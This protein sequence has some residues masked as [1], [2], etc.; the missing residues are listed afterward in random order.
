MKRIFDMYQ[1]QG[2]PV[3]TRLLVPENQG[4]NLL[5]NL[6][7]E[8][9]IKI[10]G[11]LAEPMWRKLSLV[12]Q[13]INVIASSDPL[14]E[15]IV[16]PIL[17][18]QDLEARQNIPFKEYGKYILCPSKLV[19]ANESKVHSLAPRSQ[20]LADKIKQVNP[21]NFN[22]LNPKEAQT[23]LQEKDSSLF[24]KA[25]AKDLF[26]GELYGKSITPYYFDH[27]AQQKVNKIRF[28][29]FNCTNYLITFDADR[30][31]WI[32]NQPT[33]ITFTED[34]CQLL[35]YKSNF[36]LHIYNSDIG[37]NRIS[38][39]KIHVNDLKLENL[40]KISWFTTWNELFRQRAIFKDLGI[41]VKKIVQFIS[42]NPQK[43]QDKILQLNLPN[44]NLLSESEVNQLMENEHII[45]LMAILFRYVYL[46]QYRFVSQQKMGP[47]Q[48][49]T[50]NMTPYVINVN[51]EGELF[52]NNHR[53]LNSKSKPRAFAKEG[54]YH[55]FIF[56]LTSMYY[57]RVDDPQLKQMSIK[58]QKGKDLQDLDKENQKLKGTV[59][60]VGNP[61]ISSIPRNTIE[62]AER[63]S[64][65]LL[66]S[67]EMD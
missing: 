54:H 63:Y 67:K 30:T 2:Y 51:A 48:I 37:K 64:R 56:D 21:P 35:I 53:I 47:Y 46:P 33:P 52:L 55:F 65:T 50:F 15:S 41:E 4:P 12:S 11:Y 31:L 45:N 19:L 43:M 18:P 34:D 20:T 17:L 5:E 13:K 58:D 16:K 26:G 7:E 14:W 66:S 1:A 62:L 60:I 49:D 8:L 39:I 3:D 36:Y 29:F 61:E 57:K 9:V 42:R 24:I 32:D 6:P 40:K 22:L 59:Y 44:F 38:A 28:D 23:L 27:V 25:A 10:F